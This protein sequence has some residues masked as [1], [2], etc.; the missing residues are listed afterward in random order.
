MAES[1]CR[2]DGKTD[3]LTLGMHLL[4]SFASIG[5]FCMGFLMAKMPFQYP[6]HYNTGQ[7]LGSVSQGVAIMMF[8][9]L[10]CLEA[11]Y[12]TRCV[13]HNFGFL[14]HLCGKALY[15]CLMAFY[16]IPVYEG[17]QALSK[18]DGV[19]GVTAGI[20]MF[21]VVVAFLASLVHCIVF[22]YFRTPEPEVN[23]AAVPASRVGSPGV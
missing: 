1:G 18:G 4:G 2:C 6:D 8:S 20:A 21:G 13:K 12:K 3:R 22:A 15:Y 17:L 7:W 16:A 10:S 9:S 11:V 19:D 5:L 23:L 14:T